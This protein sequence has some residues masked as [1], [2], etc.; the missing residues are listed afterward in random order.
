MSQKLDVKE[1]AMNNLQSTVKFLH[2]HAVPLPLLLATVKDTYE[3][4]RN[5]NV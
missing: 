3:K 1:I 5:G 2:G 4:A